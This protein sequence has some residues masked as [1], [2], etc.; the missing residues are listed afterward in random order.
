MTADEKRFEELEEGF[1]S[2]SGSAFSKAFRQTLD[3]GLSVLVSDDGFIYEVFPNGTRRQI[4]RIDP[5][6]AVEKGKKITIP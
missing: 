5:P 4:K 6:T 2:L 3:S 1:P